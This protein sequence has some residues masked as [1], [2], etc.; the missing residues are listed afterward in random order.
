VLALYR[1]AQKINTMTGKL[2]D[3]FRYFQM[4]APALAAVCAI[5]DDAPGPATSDKGTTSLGNYDIE[6]KGVR[7]R[8]GDRDDADG[9][10]DGD[11]EGEGDGDGDG[12]GSKGVRNRGG[13][14]SKP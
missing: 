12:G 11:R 3:K 6:F 14:G 5:I 2:I 10:G 13:G 8:Y 9:D 1:I 7:F 4:T